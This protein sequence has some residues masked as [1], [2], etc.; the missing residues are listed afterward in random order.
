LAHVFKLNKF[1]AVTVSNIS[2]PP[3]LP[4][5][6]FFSYV[7]GGWILGANVDQVQFSTDIGIQWIKDNLIQ[8][9][10]GSIALGVSLSLIFGPISYFLLQKFR[11][12]DV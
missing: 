1:V 9:V 8:Y 6:I 3:M 12:T 2:M 4:F 7:I 11:K 5:V 10:I